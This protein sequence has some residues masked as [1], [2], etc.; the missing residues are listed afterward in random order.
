MEVLA[1]HAPQDMDK[2][3]AIVSLVDR[4]VLH[5]TRVFVLN[6][7]LIWFLEL[8]DGVLLIVL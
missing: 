5:V 1:A 8:M 4:T 6:V 7:L 3:E 2:L